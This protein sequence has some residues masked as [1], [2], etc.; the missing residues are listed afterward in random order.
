MFEHLYNSHQ[1][2]SCIVIC[3]GPSL[4]KVSRLFLAENITFGT[5]KI[6]MFPF[7]PNYYVSVNPLVIEQA[8]HEIL[9]MNAAVKFVAEAF[10]CED[11][12]PLHSMKAP[13]FSYDPTR[14][15]Y[16]GHTVTFVCLQLAFFM[17]F[18]RVGIV[19]MD[20]RYEFVGEPNE[21]LVMTGDD[22][23]H[24]HP[25]YFKGNE[26]HAP[27]LVRS[28][29]AYRMAKEAFEAEDRYIV[30]LTPDSALSEDIFPKMKV[31]EW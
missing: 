29:E 18:R 28:E 10:A 15:V 25:D 19:G 6:F 1:D 7:I 24:F 17:G 27:D 8:W 31:S 9:N 14:Y 3:N 4:K 26:W 30:N 20:H 21:K 22:P 5:N 23:N 12:L 13:M 11:L 2:D 16:E